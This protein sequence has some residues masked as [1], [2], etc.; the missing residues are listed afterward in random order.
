MI[1]CTLTCLQVYVEKTVIMFV[2][3][4]HHISLAIMSFS[5]FFVLSQEKVYSL[6]RS[7]DLS[8]LQLQ[9]YCFRTTAGFYIIALVSASQLSASYCY[10]KCQ[11]KYRYRYYHN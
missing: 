6:K 7:F 11:M 8:L 3:L 5:S 10:I 2:H 9:A 1:I 4:L